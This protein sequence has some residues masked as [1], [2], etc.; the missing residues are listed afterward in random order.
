MF[1][2]PG[3]GSSQPQ[4]LS[5]PVVSLDGPA[6]LPQVSLKQPADGSRPLHAP[7]LSAEHLPLLGHHLR[8]ARRRWPV[9]LL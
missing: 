5:P 7:L 4:D 9:P 1:V 2:D 8:K 6:I 3:V